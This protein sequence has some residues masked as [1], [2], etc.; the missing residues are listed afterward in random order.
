M[1]RLIPGIVAVIIGT[2]LAGSWS[3]FR[4]ATAHGQL[5]A[6]VLTV[7]GKISRTNRGPFDSFNDAFF[8]YHDIRFE[9]A[10]AFSRQDLQRLGLAELEVSYPNWPEGT[11]V[12]HG[13]WLADILDVVGAEGT[14]ISVQALDGY[15]ADFDLETVRRNK[16][17]IAVER[18]GQPLSVGGRGPAWLVFPPG[19]YS[20][21]PSDSDD[22]L[23]WSVFHIRVE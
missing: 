10:F 15:A 22:G 3:A 20:D 8:G 11:N 7:T 2:F 14:R 5:E 19:S 9:R 23:V 21:Q 18:N 4:T 16:F 1:K 13:P 6:T 12:F 17:M